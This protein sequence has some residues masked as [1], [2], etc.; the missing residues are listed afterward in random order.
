MAKKIS[1]GRTVLWIATW[2]ADEECAADS[3]TDADAVMTPW[4]SPK[5][6]ADSAEVRRDIELVADMTPCS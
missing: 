5:P 1:Y 3:M 6:W 2:G 4:S